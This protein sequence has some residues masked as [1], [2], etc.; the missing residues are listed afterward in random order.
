MSIFSLSIIWTNI[1]TICS[2]NHFYPKAFFNTAVESKILSAT[3][4]MKNK[5]K[6]IRSRKKL[7]LSSAVS[8]SGHPYL[9][10]VSIICWASM[11]SMPL[12]LLAQ[13][14]IPSRRYNTT[15]ERPQKAAGIYNVLTN[16][17]HRVSKRLLPHSSIF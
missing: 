12:S 8:G 9:L 10:E 13:C 4:K 1:P 3:R 16:L 2:P 14:L 5:P 15:R 11:Y 17:L 6:R 7:Q